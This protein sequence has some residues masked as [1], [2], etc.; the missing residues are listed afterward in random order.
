MMGPTPADLALGR[1]LAGALRDAKRKAVGTDEETV[2]HYAHSLEA[3][4]A[5][6]DRLNAKEHVLFEKLTGYCFKTGLGDGRSSRRID[7]VAATACACRA[8]LYEEFIWRLGLIEETEFEPEMKLQVAQMIEKRFRRQFLD[9]VFQAIYST[10]LVFGRE[11]LPV[12]VRS[13]LQASLLNA[14]GV[15]FEELSGA[16]YEAV[17]ESRENGLQVLDLDELVRKSVSIARRV[18]ARREYVSMDEPFGWGHEL[19]IFDTLVGG[20][21]P[22]DVL[23]RKLEA[24]E[25]LSALSDDD[26]SIVLLDLSGM[27]DKEISERLE[28]TPGTAKKRRQ[29]AWKRVALEKQASSKN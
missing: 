10:D 2:P 5:E 18:C 21:D 23:E 8:C 12:V 29:R 4:R 13:Q 3:M 25:A 28:I 1:R 22:A 16:V 20:E 27:T 19:S 7:F 6:Y 15:S 11:M 24:E 17:A 14:Q 26:R 9:A